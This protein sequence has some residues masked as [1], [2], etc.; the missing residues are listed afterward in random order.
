MIAKMPR[1]RVIL[2]VSARKVPFI[3]AEERWNSSRRSR[4]K[5]FRFVSGINKE[6][7][8]GAWSHLSS[9]EENLNVLCEMKY[10]QYDFF[11]CY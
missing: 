8:I 2:H 5:E 3:T 9:W 10:S 7:K 4:R 11:V 1:N 6:C